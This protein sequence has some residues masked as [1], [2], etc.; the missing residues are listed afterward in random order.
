M[1]RRPEWSNSY[2]SNTS[3][4]AVWFGQ[5]A[6]RLRFA[7][8]RE[9]Q[10]LTGADARALD[11]MI[12]ELL[13]TGLLKLDS[14]GLAIDLGSANF[15][16]DGKYRLV[17]TGEAG[18]YGITTGTQ[19]VALAFTDTRRQTASFSGPERRQVWDAERTRQ[20][21]LEELLRRAPG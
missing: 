20:K 5:Q 4:Y 9:A 14:A 19:K 17:P 11:E 7:T 12:R 13:R 18:V 10:D 8:E 15:R 16:Q 1:A 21:R 2:F 3:T 6:V